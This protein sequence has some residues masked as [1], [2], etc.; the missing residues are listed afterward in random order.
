MFIDKEKD[1]AYN[2]ILLYYD[3]LILDK[4][5]HLGIQNILCIVIF[6]YFWFIKGYE[7]YY[8]YLFFII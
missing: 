8:N 3:I 1:F 6:N 4:L 7:Y 2:N 5:H